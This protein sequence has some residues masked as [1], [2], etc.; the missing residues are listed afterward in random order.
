MIFSKF[1]TSV[2]KQDEAKAII[3]MLQPFTDCKFSFN[4]ILP[5]KILIVEH[6]ED[7]NHPEMLT[8]IL[9]MA[10][11]ICIDIAETLG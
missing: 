4:F 6:L 1:K 9:K 10:G 8:D 3:Q 5:D 11:F 7:D 2:T